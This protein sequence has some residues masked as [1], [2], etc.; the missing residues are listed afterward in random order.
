MEHDG[1]RH[2]PAIG[3][4]NAVAAA[5]CAIFLIGTGLWNISFFRALVD[6]AG[7]VLASAV[8]LLAWSSRHWAVSGLLMPVCLGQSFVAVL[9]TLQ[10]ATN[11]ALGIFSPP[12]GRS[13]SW[14]VAIWCVDVGC[15]LAAMLSGGNGR[16][17]WQPIRGRLALP[18]ANYRH[19]PL[20]WCVVLK[21][22]AAMIF[23]HEIL[24]FTG[25]QLIGLL[26]RVFGGWLLVCIVLDAGFR[27]PY[28]SV[29]SGLERAR[30]RADNAELRADSRDAMLHAINEPV[31]MLD[32]Q[33][34]FRFVSRAAGLLF[35][36]DVRELVPRSWRQVG[37]SPQMMEPVEAVCRQVMRDGVIVAA[38]IFP[39]GGAKGKVLEVQV[40]LSRD[41]SGGSA[42]VAVLRDVSARLAL[43]ETL[44][45]V[46]ADRKTLKE[47]LHHRVRNN[48]QVLWSIFQMQS[49]QVDD[50]TYRRMFEQACGRILCLARVHELLFSQETMSTV[51]LWGFLEA[52]QGDLAGLYQIPTHR[53]VLEA[54]SGLLG[55]RVPLT[56]A[57]PLALIAYELVSDGLGNIAAQDHATV[58]MSLSHEVGGKGILSVR[59]SGTQPGAPN[60]DAE[61]APLGHRMVS[62]LTQ[63]LCGTL[64]VRQDTDVCV[65]LSFPWPED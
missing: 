1:S 5:A 20:L 48:L 47:E 54:K 43:E 18:L 27:Q 46:L 19:S 32:A 36:R 13:P 17:L 7:V 15:A 31:V 56:L 58:T 59:T 29:W 28:A 21:S 10:L 30:R 45:T 37:L 55:H 8:V 41:E 62:V 22:A 44:R 12:M 35:G 65:Y 33:M 57:E 6:I 11:P 16:I 25:E 60:F 34:R 49:W 42:A 38:T 50:P 4:G 23:L 9:L 26:C 14:E 2:D 53:L 52:L 64:S 51:D 63:Q 61:D 24:P 3:R 40:W 39:E